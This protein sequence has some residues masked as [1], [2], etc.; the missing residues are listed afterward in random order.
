MDPIVK[1]SDKKQLQ[2]QFCVTCEIEFPTLDDHKS[3]YKLEFHSFNLKRKMVDLPP[4]SQTVFDESL[5]K[6][7]E[8]KLKM[9]SG[10][11]QLK[12]HCKICNKPFKSEETFNQ[13]LKSKKH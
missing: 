7:K 3:H 6:L 4:V 10:K 5:R 13:H 11:T 2:G 12:F 1:Q 9:I 8:S